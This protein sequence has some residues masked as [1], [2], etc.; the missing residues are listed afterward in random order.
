MKRTVQ[1]GDSALA[2]A[3]RWYAYG[4]RAAQLGLPPAPPAGQEDREAY[5]DGRVET[6]RVVM[7]RSA[8]E[9]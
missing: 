4:Q 3:D 9:R 1:F 5:L 8:G 2:R 7:V 6:R